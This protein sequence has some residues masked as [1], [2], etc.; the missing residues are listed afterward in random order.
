M[1]VP[2]RR[3][4]AARRTGV[5]VRRRGLG[6][7]ERH[8]VR[9]RRQPCLLDRRVVD[10]LPHGRR[11]VG[12]GA[13]RRGH[14]ERRGRGRRL[15]R[16]RHH[17]MAG[18]RRTRRALPGD[19]VRA[20]RARAGSSCAPTVSGITRRA[21]STSP[22]SSVAAPAIASPIELSR[23]LVDA[24]LAAGG[25]DNITVV[26]VDVTSDP[27]HRND[28]WRDTVTTFR[29]ETHQNPYIPVGATSVNAVV[30]I[31]ASG[32]LGPRP[33][34][35]ARTRPRSSSSTSRAR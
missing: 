14:D 20:R 28:H 27:H 17:A 25:H 4:R 2:W 9:H 5:H 3:A 23:S 13:G 6:R 35:P 18:R 22:S 34:P 19:V 21:R 33:R 12:T 8:R 10:R 30:S 11:L 16:A 32:S 7:H 1:R 31:T 26:V 29:S 15:P 24:A